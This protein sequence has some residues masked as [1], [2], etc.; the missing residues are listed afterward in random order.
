MQE[1]ILSYERTNKYKETH[2]RI[3]FNLKQN[4]LIYHLRPA[5]WS[6]GQSLLTTNH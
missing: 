3:C 4:I 5:S 6:S 1:D 2:R